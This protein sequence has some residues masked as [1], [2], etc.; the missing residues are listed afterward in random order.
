V[1]AVAKLKNIRVSPRKL[2][3]VIDVARGKPVQR[4]IDDL[5]F[6]KNQMAGDVVKLIRSAI[7]NA[8]QQ[9]RGVNVDQL[10]VKTIYV[11]QG[12]TLK[13]FMTRARGSAARIL[14]RMSHLTVIVDEAGE[15]QGNAKN[16][17]AAKQ[18]KAKKTT[19]KK[20][21]KS[22]GKGEE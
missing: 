8:T 14:K 19:A 12:P 3:L 5:R 16:A 2:R 1:E 22:A 11:D 6:S 21:K 10:I 4:A 9:Q 18:P 13:R 17:K 7:N 15:A 20:T